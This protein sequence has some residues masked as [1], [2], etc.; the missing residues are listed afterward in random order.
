MSSRR[1]LDAIDSAFNN[2]AT[3]SDGAEEQVLHEPGVERL[4]ELLEGCL[5]EV[6]DSG[7]SADAVSEALVKKGFEE[8]GWSEDR[9][10]TKDAFDTLI[11]SL[12]SLEEDGERMEEN[13]PDDGDPEQDKSVMMALPLVQPTEQSGEDEQ[14]AAEQS[15]KLVEKMDAVEIQSYLDLEFKKYLETCPA[16]ASTSK[17]E[18]TTEYAKVLESS[19]SAVKQVLPAQ[20]P[21]K[22][23]APQ[24][25]AALREQVKKKR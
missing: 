18:T 17:K 9:S 2:N 25:Y 19:P 21:P 23:A 12:C 6:E 3:E 24:Y 4:Q 8:K 20:A 11:Q 5:A 7:V 22:F 1:L 14:I 10:F 16:D 13:V 15:L